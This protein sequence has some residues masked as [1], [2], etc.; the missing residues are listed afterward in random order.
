MGRLEKSTIG[1]RFEAS[2]CV[3]ASI[4][5][6]GFTLETSDSAEAKSDETPAGVGRLTCWSIE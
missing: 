5:F 6:N 4:L 2:C 3:L 1:L